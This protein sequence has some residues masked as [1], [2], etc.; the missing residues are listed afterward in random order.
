MSALSRLSSKGQLT[1]P[2]DVR[3]RLD[4]SPGTEFYV[5]VEGG[6]VLATPK[7]LTGP[8]EANRKSVMDLAGILGKPPNGRSFTIEEIDEAIINA[9]VEDDER[10]QREWNEGHK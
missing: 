8:K 3:D 4:L 6:R 7:N 10:I 2:K 9:V 5:T 1:I